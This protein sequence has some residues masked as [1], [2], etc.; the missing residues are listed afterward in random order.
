[1]ASRV[2][3][4]EVSDQKDGVGIALLPVGDHR[5]RAITLFC[6]P[7]ARD[8]EEVTR[9]NDQ[10]DEGENLVLF[11]HLQVLGRTADMVQLHRMQSG[12][13]FDAIKFPIAQ[14]DGLCIRR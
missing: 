6:Y 10:T 11:I 9:L 12:L 5:N 4:I 8:I 7:N 3:Q 14:K 2:W 13:K 1:M